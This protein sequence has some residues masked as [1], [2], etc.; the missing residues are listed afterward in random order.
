MMSVRFALHSVCHDLTPKILGTTLL[1]LGCASGCLR[2]AEDLRPASSTCD[3]R[4]VECQE[5]VQTSLSDFQPQDWRRPTSFGDWTTTIDGRITVERDLSSAHLDQGIEVDLDMYRPLD[6]TSCDQSLC[7]DL[8]HDC[9]EITEADCVGCQEG[10]TRPC[11]RECHEGISTCVEGAY[12]E[13]SALPVTSE[14]CDGVDNDC[15]GMTDESQVCGQLLRQRCGVSLGLARGIASYPDGPWENFPFHQRPGCDLMTNAD[16]ETYNCDSTLAGDGLRTLQVS[17]TPVGEADWL[18][19]AWDCPQRQDED[20]EALSVL[21]A[22]VLNWAREHCHVA[23]G[24]RD[25]LS[26][27]LIDTLSPPECLISSRPRMLFSPRCVQTTLPSQY[28]ILELEGMVND[29]DHLAIAFYCTLTSD[30]MSTTASRIG[31]APMVNR[32]MSELTVILGVNQSANNLNQDGDE[33]W[34]D[35]QESER[36]QTGSRRG[37]Y[38]SAEGLFSTFRLSRRLTQS[39]QVLIS[40]ILRPLSTD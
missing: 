13:C 29:D 14:V 22:A 15:D 11:Q 28:S 40:L 18:G 38:S 8:G 35:L 23:L 2:T 3:E 34:L 9:D 20:T 26:G 19:I 27:D 32:V 25:Y 10:S 31:D 33:I 7:G 21:E 12:Q 37:V 17:H 1:I 5:E 16:Q 24:Y 4:E 30:S 6:A 36:D 39:H